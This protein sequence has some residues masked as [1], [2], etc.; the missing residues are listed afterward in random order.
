M[1]IH[2]S[3]S[4]YDLIFKNVSRFIDLTDEEKELYKSLLKSGSAKRKEFVLRPGKITR[5]EYFVTKGCLKVYSI[6]RNGAE[7]VSMFAIE[8]FWTGDMASF[9]LQQ[10]STYFIKALEDSEFLMISKENY[11]RLFEEIPKFE[12]FYR[13]IYQRSLTN[14]IRRANQGISLTAEER[15]EIFLTKYPHIANRITQ[16]DLAA[17]LGITPEFLSMIRSKMSKQ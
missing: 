1:K 6:D 14:Y 15:Y 12:R 17:Y 7:H 13:N 5:Y 10:P 2:D 8:D 4:A 3:K 9:M 16:K 11:E